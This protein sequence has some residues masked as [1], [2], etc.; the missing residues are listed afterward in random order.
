MTFYLEN[1]PEERKPLQKECPYLELCWSVF[2]RIRTEYREIRSRDGEVRSISPY[3]VEIRENEDQ[4]NSE[5]GHFLRSGRDEQNSIGKTES[6]NYR[7][8]IETLLV[9]TIEQLW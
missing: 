9:N 3:S 2:S 4:H 6:K 1:V 5:C 8:K 7:K